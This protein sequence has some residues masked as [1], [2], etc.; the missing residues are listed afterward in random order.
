MRSI[1]AELTDS[2]FIGLPVQ[3]GFP[4]PSSM[5][6]KLLSFSLPLI[7]CGRLI[8]LS[9][10]LLSCGKLRSLFLP[11]LLCGRLR[12]SVLWPLLLLCFRLRASLLL[13]VSLCSVM[14]CSSGNMLQNKVSHR[15]LVLAYTCRG[16]PHGR[17]IA[18]HASQPQ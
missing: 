15:L 16:L 6:C 13:P 14:A 7:S 10:P 3:S 11:L 8:L 4:S 5:C 12:I 9:L 1:T 18:L 2:S 17:E